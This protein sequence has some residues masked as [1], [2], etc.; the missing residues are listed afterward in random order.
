MTKP[1]ILAYEDRLLNYE[2]CF[3][4]GYSPDPDMFENTLRDIK[5]LIFIVKTFEVEDDRRNTPARI[6]GFGIWNGDQ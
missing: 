3:D 1:Y 5:D 2:T 6:D 4:M